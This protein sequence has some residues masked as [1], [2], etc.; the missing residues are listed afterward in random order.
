[1]I[2]YANEFLLATNKKTLSKFIPS[3]RLPILLRD[4]R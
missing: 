2:V 4:V 3:T 1:M